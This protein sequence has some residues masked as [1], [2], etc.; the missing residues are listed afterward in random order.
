VNLLEKPARVFNQPVKSSP[1]PRKGL[2]FKV[3]MWLL[4]PL[5]AWW[6]LKDLSL[7]DISGSLRQVGVTA[8]LILLGINIFIF[9][10]ISLRWWMILRAQ[11][12]RVALYSVIGYRLAG[13]GLT[14]FTPGPQFGGEPAQV[15][16]LKEKEGIPI[17]PA[18]TSV[19]I[20][21][22][23]E[24]LANFSFLLVGVSVLLG[25]GRMHSG[26]WLG[27]ILF[28]VLLLSVPVIY[29]LA[30][31]SEFLPVSFISHGVGLLY[32]QC[33]SFT[34]WCGSFDCNLGIDDI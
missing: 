18:A 17:S 10:L 34:C 7:S 12:W 3:L 22:L 30:L 1:S 20:D 9:I 24:L 33:G 23:L 27:V 13:F 31:R 25:S 28:P 8:I 21:K 6:S 11:G 32:A 14:Y 26:S 19:A 29:L 15:Y 5:A 16:L 2:V 4:V